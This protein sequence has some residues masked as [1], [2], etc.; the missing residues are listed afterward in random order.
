MLALPQKLLFYGIVLVFGGSSR[1]FGNKGS[2]LTYDSGPKAGV[3]GSW[4]EDFIIIHCL[5][6]FLR[7]LFTDI[8]L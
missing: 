2:S 5:V 6:F 4:R 3:S 7:Y 8:R 1:I